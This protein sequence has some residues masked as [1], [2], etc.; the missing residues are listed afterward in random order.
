ME[1]AL[2]I[3]NLVSQLTAPIARALQDGLAHILDVAAPLHRWAPRTGLPAGVPSEVS[4]ALVIG[5]SLFV[6]GYLVLRRA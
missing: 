3:L 5:L 6:V 1:Y 4:L 2:N